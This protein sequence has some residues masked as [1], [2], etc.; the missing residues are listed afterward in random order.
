MRANR[1]K[2]PFVVLGV[3]AWLLVVAIVFTRGYPAIHRLTEIAFCVVG[4]ALAVIVLPFRRQWDREQRAEAGL[5]QQCGYDLRA[6]AGRC[7]ECGAVV[8]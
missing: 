7:P 8:R 4:V 5:C 1:W 6:S 2:R 3:L